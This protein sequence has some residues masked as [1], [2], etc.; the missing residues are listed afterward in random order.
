MYHFA[1]DVLPCM[2]S[3]GGLVLADLVEWNGK[4][5]CTKMACRYKA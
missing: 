2:Y 1:H 3:R 5:C 4:D